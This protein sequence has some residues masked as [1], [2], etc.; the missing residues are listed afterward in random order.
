[1]AALKNPKHERFCLEYVKDL[2]ATQAA[3]R[4]GYSG[5]TA[6]EQGS[7]LLSKVM[8]AGRVTELQAKLT[9]KLEITA[10]RVLRETA[11]LAFSD[12]RKYFNADGTLKRLVDLDDDAAAALASFESVEKAIPGGEGETEEVRKFKI[13]DKP[14]ALGMLGKHLNL[15]TE[16][17]EI[18]EDLAAALDRARARRPPP[19]AR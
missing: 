10:E 15:F 19:R 18:G 3:I 4:T 16:K 9:D 11:R 8:V 1:M 13:W 2:N 17:L 14:S 5:K 12:P 7:R 6:Q